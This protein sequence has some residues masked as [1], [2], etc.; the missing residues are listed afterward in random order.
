MEDYAICVPDSSIEVMYVI[1]LD[2]VAY[3]WAF[4]DGDAVGSAI[5]DLVVAQDIVIG[6]V[7]EAHGVCPAVVVI[8]YEPL[9]D[10]VVGPSEVDEGVTADVPQDDLLTGVGAYSD[11]ASRDTVTDGTSF[12]IHA[13]LVHLIHPPGAGH[14]APDTHCITWDKIVQV[15]GDGPPRAGPGAIPIAASMV[16]H[17]PVAN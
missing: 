13:D 7:L 8:H 11:R 6:A 17:I 1:V 10:P 12:T 16:V 15:I 5:V 2:H 14:V 4:V 3:V 9:K